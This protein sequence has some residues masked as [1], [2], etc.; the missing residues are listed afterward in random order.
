M[1]I[2]NSDPSYSA[3]DISATSALK[4]PVGT[5]AERPSVPKAGQIRYNTSTKQFEGCGDSGTWQ[6]LGG[7]I[8]VDQDTFILAET[9]PDEDNDQIQIFTASAERM[10]VDA[11]GNIQMMNS[12][13]DYSALDINATSALSNTSGHRRSTSNK[14]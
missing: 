4:I 5:N 3:L 2:V 6:G 7:I 13:P 11:C 10:K 8:D 9:S 12:N 1:K 14:F